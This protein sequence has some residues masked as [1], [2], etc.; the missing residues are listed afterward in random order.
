MRFLLRFISLLFLVVAVITGVV[1]AIQTVAAD[2]LNL[3][4]LG[5]ALDAFSPDS[6]NAT[7]SFIQRS[8]HPLLWDPVIQWVLLQPAVA[9]F[10]TLSLVFYLLGY[11][12]PKPA[13]RFAA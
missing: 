13:G 10:L 1:D 9:V 11:K 6:L 3:T 8:I 12:R 2:K 5:E 4:V 7:Q